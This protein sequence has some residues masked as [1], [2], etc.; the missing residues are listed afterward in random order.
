[1]NDNNISMPLA[2]ASAAIA[3]ATGAQAL[4][5]A[6]TTGSVLSDLLV[7]SWPNIAAALAAIYSLSLLCEWFWKKVWRPLFERWGWIKP[8][9]HLVLTAREWAER[10][11]AEE[12]DR[13][14]L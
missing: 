13:A 8:K 9:P 10:I 12:S 14:P 4:D 1:M 7:L 5:G 11:A 2:K 6:R 3:T